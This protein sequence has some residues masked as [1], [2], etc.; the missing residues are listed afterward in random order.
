M[1]ILIYLV[2]FIVYAVSPVPLQLVAF[3]A[4]VLIDD[5]IPFIDE[6]FMVYCTYKRLES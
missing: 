3:L 6:L 1:T 2:L 5:P 4:N